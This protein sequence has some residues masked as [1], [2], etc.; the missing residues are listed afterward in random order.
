M[1]GNVQAPGAAPAPTSLNVLL[2]EDDA[3]IAMDIQMSVED[4]GHVVVATAT[5]AD[6]AVAAADR[7]CPDVALMDLRL[8]DGSFGGDAARTI[9]RRH[10]VRSI[11]LSGNLDPETRARLADL[12]PIAMINKPFLPHELTR[13]LE[14]VGE[15]AN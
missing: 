3:L 14:A 6:E 12:E 7:V 8:A 2:V 11:F 5:T 4:A 13:A 1:N 9:L 15:I 10:G